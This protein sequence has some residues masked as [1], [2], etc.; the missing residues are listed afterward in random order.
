VWITSSLTTALTPT[1]VALGNFDG[2]HRG[3]RQV[4]QPILKESGTSQ[5]IAVR[6][7]TIDWQNQFESFSFPDIEENFDSKASVATGHSYATVVTFNPHPHQFF[8]GQT[9]QLLTP[10]SEKAQLLSMMG[11]E[12]LVLLPFNQEL[13]SL[14]PQQ[15]VE[16]ILVQQLQVKRVSVGKDFHFGYKRAGTSDDLKAIASSYGIDVTIVSLHTCQ[17]ERISSSMIRQS[18]LQ[19]DILQANR[20]LGRP[21]TL[22]GKVVQGQQMGR[23]IGFPTAN[24]QLPSEKFLP[25]QGVYSV[26]VYS[27]LWA[28]PVSSQPGVMNIG[29]RPT[30][31]GTNLTVEIHLLDWS[32]DLYGQTLTVSL[33]QF[34]RPEQKFASLDALKSQIQADSEAARAFLGHLG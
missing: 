19:G 5:A 22:T 26:R 15:F 11:V 29:Q 16:K 3:H 7:L 8:S 12:Q 13:A 2:I 32:G 9:R 14:S 20:L 21:Y 17:G 28:S 1:A 24:L 6:P 25:K 31:N 4:I 30:V 10:P 34:L 18:L 27:P 33:E 23:T